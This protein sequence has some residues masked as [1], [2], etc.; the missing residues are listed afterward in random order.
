[1]ASGLPTVASRVSGSE[2]F[3]V[4]GRNGWLF[5]ATDGAALATCLREAASLSRERLHELGR[6]A[7]ADVE[8]AAAL[9]TVVGRLMAIYRGAH[10]RELAKAG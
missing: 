1:M 7:R 3:V 8:S 9:D 4:P 2:D 5:E 6:H 10:P